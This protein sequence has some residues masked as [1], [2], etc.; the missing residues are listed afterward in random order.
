MPLGC[1]L[2]G[3]LGDASCK[4]TVLK[5]STVRAGERRNVWVHVPQALQTV[6]REWRVGDETIALGVAPLKMEA[7]R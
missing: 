5:A 1:P 6:P 3:K 7:G 2:S 4:V